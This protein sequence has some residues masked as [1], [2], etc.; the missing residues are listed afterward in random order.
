[1]EQTK[2]LKDTVAGDVLYVFNTDGL[3]PGKI[4]KGTIRYLN[5]SDDAYDIE[6]LHI[7]VID[8]FDE[9][10]ETEKTLMFVTDDIDLNIDQLVDQNSF[11]SYAVST[12]EEEIKSGYF[13]YIESCIEDAEYYLKE[14]TELKEKTESWIK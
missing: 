3:I 13:E 10:T 11:S 5:E 14:L 6:E 8:V 4:C 9:E 1:M 7:K 12:S 2:A